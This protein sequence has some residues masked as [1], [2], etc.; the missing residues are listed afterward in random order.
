LA[1]ARR[2]NK[3]SVHFPLQAGIPHDKRTVDVAP[4]STTSEHPASVSISVHQWLNSAL[5]IW[6]RRPRSRTCRSTWTWS[7]PQS[8]VVSVRA[9]SQSQLHLARFGMILRPG[10]SLM[11]WPRNTERYV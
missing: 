10:Y 11:S 1:E 4:I 7:A 3:I 8:S 6:F 2:E 9:T 5:G